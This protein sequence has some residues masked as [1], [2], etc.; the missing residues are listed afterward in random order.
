MRYYFIYNSTLCQL[1]GTWFIRGPPPQAKRPCWVIIDVNPA[2]NLSDEQVWSSARVH[3]EE[4]CGR[5]ILTPIERVLNAEYPNEDGVCSPSDHADQE[6]SRVIVRNPSTVK[7]LL[8]VCYP[9]QVRVLF[10]LDQTDF[11][12][13]QLTGLGFSISSSYIPRS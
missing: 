3:P 7:L 10:F 13:M 2:N 12:N 11:R 9:V 4:S 6:V 5:L 8:N 1:K